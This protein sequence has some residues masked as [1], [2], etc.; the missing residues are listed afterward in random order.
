M[1]YIDI[2]RSKTITAPVVYVVYGSLKAAK[3][4]QVRAELV[5][6]ISAEG[7]RRD[8]WAGMDFI[9]DGNEL[10]RPHTQRSNK[11]LTYIQSWSADEFDKNNPEHV[12]R[13]HDLGAETA[14][15]LAPNSPFL[16]A[17]HTDSDGGCVHN[18]IIILNHD[19][20][21][22]LAAPKQAGNFY[23]VKRVNDELMHEVG[24]EVL[25]PQGS[26][27]KLRQ[28]EKAAAKA[29]I[30]TDS[31][32]LGLHELDGY[33]WA[34]ALRKRVD[35]LIEDE[36]VSG[37]SG[38]AE[39]T[40][41]AQE[42]APE[43]DLSLQIN[44]HNALTIGLVDESGET[45]T[46]ESGIKRKR[47]RK[48]VDAGSKFGAGYSLEGIQQRITEQQQLH[49]LAV[50]RQARLAGLADIKEEIG[51]I[52]HVQ[53]NTTANIIS[54]R[55]RAAGMGFDGAANRGRGNA[56]EV[57]EID[58]RETDGIGA[59]AS[60]YRAADR[61]SGHTGEGTAALTAAAT[62]AKRAAA[63]AIADNSRDDGVQRGAESS[64][65][66]NRGDYLHVDEHGAEHEPN[67]ADAAGAEPDVPRDTRSSKASRAAI[68]KR[69]REREQ[70]IKQAIDVEFE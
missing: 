20:L 39:G 68:E 38:A 19:Y 41:T 37:A 16:V 55:N 8:E 49:A 34:D 45:L 47:R 29:G 69:R 70:R 31:S 36:R 64:G 4:G 52:E 24:M 51:D 63:A 33:T 61:E 1:S 56:G 10:L 18:H 7:L 11:C 62:A 6:A 3:E 57:A 30:S 13:A 23:N 32:E 12:Q 15:R 26:W 67:S 54:G 2:D 14:R 48:A 50:Q 65:G 60:E 46:Y 59:D 28:P 27:V 40:K 17:T 21:T 43:Y 44:E 9:D 53:E 22:G 58:G 35:A 25:Q 66:D 5:T 42:I